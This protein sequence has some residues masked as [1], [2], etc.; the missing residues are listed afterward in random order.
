MEIIN[1]IY[2]IARQQKGINSFTFNKSYQKG[3]G[4]TVYPAVWVDDP[5]QGQADGNA[6]LLFTANVDI[7]DLPSASNTVA[8]VQDWAFLAG[9]RVIEKLKQGVTVRGFSFISLRDYYDDNA[10]GFRFTLSVSLVNPVDRCADDVQP[11]KQFE[12]RPDGLPDFIVDNP[13]GCAVFGGSSLPNFSV[14]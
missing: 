3:A 12:P 5:I 8:A 14:K 4:N 9:L 6:A 10:A 13:T 1:R 2:D 7:L 11:G